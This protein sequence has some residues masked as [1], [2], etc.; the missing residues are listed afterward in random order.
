M[1]P[2]RMPTVRIEPHS[3][4]IKEKDRWL[5]HRALRDFEAAEHAAGIIAREAVAH[6]REPHHAQSFIDLLLPLSMRDQIE[7]R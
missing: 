7:A 2:H 3:R 1:I 6:L 4:F 5:M